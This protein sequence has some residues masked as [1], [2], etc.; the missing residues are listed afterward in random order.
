V[1][2]GIVIVNAGA[3]FNL[4]T[5]FKTVVNVNYLQFQQT[6]ALELL[7]FQSPIRRTIGA[8]YSLG[9]E[10]RPPLSENIVVRG[11]A[12]G[13]SPGGGLRDIYGGKTFLAA[14]GDLRFQF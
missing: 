5:K 8:D 7:L 13:L 10:Y 3:D 9:F 14:F 11:S 6:E 4:T 12:S 2:P 1:N